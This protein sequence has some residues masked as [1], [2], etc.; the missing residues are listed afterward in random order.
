MGRQSQWC[1]IPLALPQRHLLTKNCWAYSSMPQLS[2]GQVVRSCTPCML[3]H[4]CQSS[5]VL[6]CC[7]PV[8]SDLV[9]V[10]H[11]ELKRLITSLLTATPPRSGVRPLETVGLQSILGTE[12]VSAMLVWISL[13][14]S[15]M[16]KELIPI[17]IA[18]VI[19]VGSGL[20][21]LSSAN[22][23]M[24]WWSPSSHRVRLRT[25]LSCTLVLS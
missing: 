3:L 23:T 15:I 14:E 21:T 9:D 18:L 13:S 20:V 2:C 6:E 10:V 12:L 24:R 5:F 1:S 19:W 16:V 4:C 25:S 7:G 17:A 8:R 22:A 11:R